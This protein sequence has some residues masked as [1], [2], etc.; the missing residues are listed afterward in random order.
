M[1]KTFTH[2]L[3]STKMS[4]HI[5]LVTLTDDLK[6]QLNLNSNKNNNYNH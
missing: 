2:K 4:Q 3:S 5:S 6:Y 1:L